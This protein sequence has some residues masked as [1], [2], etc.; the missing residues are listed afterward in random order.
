MLPEKAALITALITERPLCLDCIATRAS[1]TM[2]HVEAWFLAIQ[3]V[4]RLQRAE[5]KQCRTCGTIGLV[6][7]L[8]RPPD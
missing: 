2:T 4:L 1:T 5:R 6:F 7:Y 3:H 8:D